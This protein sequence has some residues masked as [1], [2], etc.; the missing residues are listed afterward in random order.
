M[1]RHSGGARCATG[2]DGTMSTRTAR[3]QEGST[4]GPKSRWQQ[5]VRAVT[6]G[7]TLVGDALVIA[8]YF[9][10]WVELFKPNDPDFRGIREYSP[11]MALQLATFDAPAVMMAVFYILTLA[12]V[13]GTL[14]FVR[15]RL[16]DARHFAA[17][18]AAG[19]A[20]PGLVLL[21][22]ILPGLHT[23]ISLSYPYYHSNLLYG[24]GL[25]LVGFVC[26]C[27]GATGDVIGLP[28]GRPAGDVK[29]V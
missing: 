1:A 11:W 25:A 27:A 2:T 15:A 29:P 14:V 18:V 23:V 4:D 21:G 16:A 24:A 9:A 12:M 28:R 19:S 7:L 17:R 6:I 13:L 22:L 26:V 8:S 20:L 5:V 10:P 3:Q